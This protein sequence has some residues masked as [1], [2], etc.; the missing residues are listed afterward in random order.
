MITF[1]SFLIHYGELSTKGDNKRAFI[2]QLLH[3]ITDALADE[4]LAYRSNRDHI[5]IALNGEDP[6]PILNRLQEIA[7]IQR[8]S[9]VYRGSR[10]LSELQAQALEL[11]QKEPG[12]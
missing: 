1:D 10:E 7:G 9:L 5:V 6:A 3:N 12:K 2:R 4:K 11:L 8:I